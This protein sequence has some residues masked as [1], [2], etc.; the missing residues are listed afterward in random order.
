MHVCVFWKNVDT[1]ENRTAQDVETSWIFQ[2]QAVD[3]GQ[4]TTTCCY[5]SRS[6]DLSC[7]CRRRALVQPSRTRNECTATPRRSRSAAPVQ[8]I[9][10]IF[11]RAAAKMIWRHRALCSEL[12][13]TRHPLQIAYPLVTMVFRLKSGSNDCYIFSILCVNCVI[14]QPEN[15]EVFHAHKIDLPV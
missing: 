4:Q 14:C 3:A 6:V 12:F 5:T 9:G 15:A 8:C 11:H 2:A 13:M 7:S 10:N 1:N